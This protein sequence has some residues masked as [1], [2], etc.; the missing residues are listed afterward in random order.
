VRKRVLVGTRGWF[1]ALSEAA[2]GKQKPQ[3][4]QTAQKKAIV[5]CSIGDFCSSEF[6]M[7]K[8]PMLQPPI[9]SH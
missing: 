2:D 3:E 7:Q 6:E 4:A 1:I 8:P 5:S 9:D